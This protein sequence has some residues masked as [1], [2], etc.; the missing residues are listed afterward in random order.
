MT[1]PIMSMRVESDLGEP[2]PCMC[3]D[4]PFPYIP[5]WNEPPP[6]VDVG[7]GRAVDVLPS[8]D[9]NGSVTDPPFV[10]PGMGKV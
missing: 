9:D 10:K 5:P 8:D 1:A 3:V 7:K 6:G 4:D 2:F